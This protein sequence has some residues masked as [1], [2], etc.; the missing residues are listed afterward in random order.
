M[1]LRENLKREEGISKYNIELSD[2]IF[3]NHSTAA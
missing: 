3:K 1:V 2:M